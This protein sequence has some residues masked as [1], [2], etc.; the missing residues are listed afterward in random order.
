MAG[1][2]TNLDIFRKM[3]GVEFNPKVGCHGF[4]CPNKTFCYDCKYK[5]FWQKEYKEPKEK[6]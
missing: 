2:I 4:E 3:F 6:R 5:D 1:I